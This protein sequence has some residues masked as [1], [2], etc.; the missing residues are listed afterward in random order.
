MC[1]WQ[2]CFGAKSKCSTLIMKFSLKQ[3]GQHSLLPAL[4]P[5][6]KCHWKRSIQPKVFKKSTVEFALTAGPPRG[7]TLWHET[8]DCT[9][10][11]VSRP[12]SLH[13]PSRSPSAVQTG[14]ATPTVLLRTHVHIHMQKA[15]KQWGKETEYLSSSQLQKRKE[16][17][18]NAFFLLF[19]LHIFSCNLMP[20]RIFF[21]LQMSNY[22]YL[23]IDVPVRNSLWCNLCIVDLDCTPPVTGTDM[24]M[25]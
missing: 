17:K 5:V 4:H 18:K 24:K 3:K 16:E 14:G 7:C 12:L 25:D 13:C 19:F 21:L 15:N 11:T 8:I 6:H 1:L 2:F 9:E 10:H 20:L 22:L 23:L